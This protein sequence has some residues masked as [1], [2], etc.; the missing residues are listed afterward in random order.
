MPVAS[1]A[2]PPPTPDRAVPVEQLSR[3]MPPLPPPQQGGEAQS[4]SAASPPGSVPAVSTS[5]AGKDRMLL[6]GP[7]AEPAAASVQLEQDGTRPHLLAP[8]SEPP[9]AEPPGNVGALPASKFG[10]DTFKRLERNG[11]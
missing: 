1:L 3:S 2:E 7:A 5:P 10:P 4:T 9:Q 11:F 6:A 8:Q